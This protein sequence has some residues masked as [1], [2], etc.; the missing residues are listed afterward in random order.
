MSGATPNPFDQL[1]RTATAA[2]K[3]LSRKASAVTARANGTTLTS[4]LLHLLDLNGPMS[5]AEIG[6][7]ANLTTRQVWG[8]LKSQRAHGLVTYED[9]L[10]SLNR[11][12]STLD[13]ARA[14]AVLRAAG[15]TVVPPG[16]VGDGL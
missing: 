16:K 5:T 1:L 11:Q 14:A 10:W 3:P 8:L 15:W 12:A 2:P 4:H 6:E 7:A 13:E 9:Q